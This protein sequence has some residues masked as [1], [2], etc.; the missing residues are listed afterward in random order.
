MIFFFYLLAHTLNKRVV[1]SQKEC[2]HSSHQ[3]LIH[4]VQFTFA[5]HMNT[6]II[7]TQHCKRLYCTSDTVKNALYG[8]FGRGNKV[9]V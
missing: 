5:Q 1:H 7:Q 9:K 3:A 4:Y 8:I 6:F 2:V